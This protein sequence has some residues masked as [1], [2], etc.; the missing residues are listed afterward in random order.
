MKRNSLAQAAARAGNSRILRQRQGKGGEA[1]VYCYTRP[2]LYALQEEAIFGPQRYS[3]IEASTKSGKTHGCLVWLLEQALQGAG[4]ANY[5][6][7]A[8]SHGQAKIA[9]SRMKRG[10][11]FLQ[12]T[13][14][15]SRPILV[16]IGD[17][18]NIYAIHLSERR[19]TLANGAT[20]WFKSGE[21]PDTLFGEDV[22]AAVLDEASRLRE[23][24]FFAVRSTL[25]A[26]NGPMRL[27]GNVKGRGNWFYKGCRRAKDGAEGHRY[28]VITAWDA[29]K[30]GVLD[31]EEILDAQ[32]T[33]PEH[34]F[35]ELYECKPTDDGWNPFGL[36]AIGRCISP[37]YSTGQALAAGWDLGRAVDWTVGAFLD[38]RG[39]LTKC[40]RFQKPWRETIQA[41]RLATGSV[42]ALVD[43]T[44]VG[45]PVVEALQRPAVSLD[46]RTEAQ[47][48]GGIGHAPYMGNFEGFEFTGQS[49]QQL[50]EDLVDAV[51]GELIHFPEGIIADE[52]REFEFQY[53]PR[54]GVRYSAPQG[55][56]DDAVIA[57]AL[58]YRKLKNR[59]R[60]ARI[61]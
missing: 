17:G 43:S 51:Q 5:W 54:G 29:V 33:L 10:L 53:T 55:C 6:W 31:L 22:K 4:G 50:I 42:P 2:V 46:V 1:R 30:A 41:I 25:T 45:S 23:E 9:F 36:A 61:R 59:P 20:I 11:K 21:K 48:R 57:L 8:P 32:R 49:K 3:W 52:M 37:V 40:E 35:G 26:T 34:I 14:H 18:E 7:V 47:G 39:F 44:G 24:A 13:A 56:H 58:A 15:E 27:I 28:F 19:I 38:G 60:P 12:H 16:P